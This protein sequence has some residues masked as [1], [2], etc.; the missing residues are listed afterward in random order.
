MGMDLVAFYESQDP[1]GAFANIAA[2]ADPLGYD[3]GDEIDL[4][5]RNLLVA[6]ALGVPSGGNQRAR[7]TAPSILRQGRMELN[8]F[9]GGADAGA[10]PNNPP[11]LY[12]FRGNPVVFEPGEPLTLE[13]DYNTTVAEEGWGLLWLSNSPIAPL[14][15]VNV[16]HVGVT[17]S[18]NSGAGAWQNRSVTFREPLGVGRYQ[19][20]GA[21]LVGTDLIAARFVFHE[22]DFGRPGVLGVESVNNHEHE[23]FRN[24]GMGVLGEF[25]NDRPPTVDLLGLTAQTIT[26]VLDLVPIG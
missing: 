3:D 23:M 8:K 24:G 13:A 10:E 20:V 18:G 5:D 14:T 6:L 9:N 7:L 21:R 16:R 11:L 19:L 12:D 25:S 22:G 1:G 2:L 15:G 26:G 4:A 17:F